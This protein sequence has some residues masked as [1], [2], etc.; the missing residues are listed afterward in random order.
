MSI[1][2]EG[3]VQVIGRELGQSAPSATSATTLYTCS[4]SRGARD[5]WVT[6]ANRST[7]TTFRVWVAKA[8]AADANA[9]YK[10]YDQPIG[11]NASFLVPI[12]SLEKTDLIRIYAGSANLSFTANGEE[13]A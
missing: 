13:L 3:G 10:A 1:Y 11:A 12:G 9:Q 6:V 7:A 2:S 5:V 8:G 4:T